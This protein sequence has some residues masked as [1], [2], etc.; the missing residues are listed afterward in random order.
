MEDEG[1][2]QQP[3]AEL[4]CFVPCCKVTGAKGRK[5][6]DG[7]RSLQYVCMVF[8]TATMGGSS[9]PIVN[10]L[11]QPL[12]QVQNVFMQNVVTKA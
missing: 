5:P 12:N 10:M 9:V 1:V 11:L 2:A 3:P 6:T 4:L 8:S 7:Q